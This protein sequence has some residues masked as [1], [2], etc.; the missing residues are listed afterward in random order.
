MPSPSQA[1]C[2]IQGSG[3]EWRGGGGWSNPL[4]KIPAHGNMGRYDASVLIEIDFYEEEI[5]KYQAMVSAPCFD[6]SW[7]LIMRRESFTLQQSEYFAAGTPG[8]HRRDPAFDFRLFRLPQ[9]TTT[10]R[11]GE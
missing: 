10:V 2:R 6:Q 4:Q 1:P 7:V 11:A 3:R 9:A 5:R 8:R